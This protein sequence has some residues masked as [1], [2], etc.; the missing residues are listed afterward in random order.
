M[1]ITTKGR[2]AV[3]AMLDL[4]I[5]SGNKPV[6]IVDISDRQMISK[7]YL[8][9]LFRR[10]RNSGIVKSVRGPGGGYLIGKS[11]N[12]ITIKD[13]LDSVGESTNLI[14]DMHDIPAYN[15]KEFLLSKDYF[16]VLGNVVND[17][18]LTSLEDLTKK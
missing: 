5:N 9:Q 14:R 18:L 11:T 16:T 13:I 6:T 12:T 2:Y 15:S 1:N 17:C 7:S 4:A 8:E 10:L 3:N